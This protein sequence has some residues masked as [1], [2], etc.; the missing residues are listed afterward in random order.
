MS[1]LSA[2]K[3]FGA[4]AKKT[5]A[6]T[7]PGARAA[8]MCLT[9]GEIFN[10]TAHMPFLP[11]A[12]KSA[13]SKVATFGQIGL[14]SCAVVLKNAQSNRC[15]HV[16]SSGKLGVATCNLG[17]ALKAG[18]AMAISGGRLIQL[19]LDGKNFSARKVWIDTAVDA[20]VPSTK[21]TPD[22]KAAKNNPIAAVQKLMTAYVKSGFEFTGHTGQF[23]YNKNNSMCL[24]TPTGKGALTK[25]Q[26]QSLQKQLV[27]LQQKIVL[28]STTPA[29]RKKLSEQIQGINDK[30]KASELAN[31][32]TVAR[33]VGNSS[34]KWTPQPIAAT[35]WTV[36]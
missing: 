19:R 6:A 22:L 34:Q 8:T 17:N 32:T 23:R 26:L 1:A 28:P 11:A 13:M 12:M 30:I 14:E 35:T 36:K 5:K 25:P 2:S 10:P 20:K 15:M 16:G 7:D 9:E 18:Q 33:C 24:A 4:A 3:Q 29:N 27:Q 31:L 21:A